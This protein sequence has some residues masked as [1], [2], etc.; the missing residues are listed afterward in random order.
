M[1][2]VLNFVSRY[3][4]ERNWRKT[5]KEKV[6][7]RINCFL[8]ILQV[9]LTSLSIGYSLN[10]SVLTSIVTFVQAVCEGTLYCVVTSWCYHVNQQPKHC[11]I[12]IPVLWKYEFSKKYCSLKNWDYILQRAFSYWIFDH[13]WGFFMSDFFRVIVCVGEG[14]FFS[15]IS[16]CCSLYFQWDVLSSLWPKGFFCGFILFIFYF[17]FQF[18][19]CFQFWVFLEMVL[20]IILHFLFL[21]YLTIF[22]LKY[23]LGYRYSCK[24]TT[25]KANIR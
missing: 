8:H 16:G 13:F 7:E 17:F 11:T 4:C 5:F 20:K 23:I 21:V 3:Y 9:Y 19:I 15:R 6:H 14:D 22:R 25:K 12:R 24:Y 10:T 2:C 1:Y 18:H